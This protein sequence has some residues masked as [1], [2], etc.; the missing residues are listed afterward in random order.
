MTNEM[1]TEKAKRTTLTWESKK[2]GLCEANLWDGELADFRFC[3]NGSLTESGIWSDNLDYL[4]ELH[5]VLEQLLTFCNK[6]K[7]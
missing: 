5:D 7:A 6:T 4:T 3:K 1:K 2:F